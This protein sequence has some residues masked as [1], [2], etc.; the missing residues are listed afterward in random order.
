MPRKVPSG[1]Q[2]R[3]GESYSS[4]GRM[5]EWKVAPGKKVEEANYRW[6]RRK[7]VKNKMKKEMVVLTGMIQQVTEHVW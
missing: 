3:R 7:E 1:V 6:K 2:S 4:K 5:E